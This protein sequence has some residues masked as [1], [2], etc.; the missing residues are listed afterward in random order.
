[1]RDATRIRRWLR[2]GLYCA[3]GMLVLF[4]AAAVTIQTPPGK[5]MLV[6][7]ITYFV[8][9]HTSFTI[10]IE[11]LSGWLPGQVR[12]ASLYLADT[13]GPFVDIE[14][15]DLRLVSA[16]LLRGRIRLTKLD[17]GHL[18]L[19]NRP[20][21]KQKWRIPRIPEIPVWPHIDA[22]NIKRM[23][24][25]EAVMGREAELAITGKVTPVEGASFPE[26]AL[27][28]TGPET[29]DTTRA[30][31][32]FHYVDGLPQ[33]WLEAY[34]ESL[35]PAFLDVPPPLVA[36]VD[37][38]GGRADWKGRVAVTAGDD[39]TLF[40][41]DARLMEGVSS[42]VE[43]D[44]MINVT[45][46]PFLSD[47]AEYLG[48]RLDAR[49]AAVLDGNGLLAV[50]SCDITSE[51]LKA[52]LGGEIQLEQK[53][54]GLS[55][56]VAHADIS[57][58]P[59]MDAD[60]GVL[61]AELDLE[62]KGPFSELA[63]A[64][65]ASVSTMVVLEADLRGG[66]AETASL[67]GVVTVYPG[68]LPLVKMPYT[69]GESLRLDFD[70]SFDE[71]AGVLQVK[72]AD[73][74]AAGAHLTFQGNYVP[75]QP[76]LNLK[77]HLDAPDLATTG[78][79]FGFALT[80]GMAGDVESS[81][82]E[83][84]LEF[85]LKLEGSGL[86]A[87]S[88]SGQQ[89]LV[90]VQGRCGEWHRMPPRA[91]SATVNAQ[92][93][94]LILADR[95]AGDWNL[96]INV[97]ADDWTKLKARDMLLTD[98]N[99]R[100]TGEGVFALSE[101]HLDLELQ[102]D[103]SSLA[104]LPVD[105]EGLPDGS[106]NARAN[107]GGTF[108]PLSLDLR[109][110]TDLGALGGLPA[111]VAALTG[112]E[113]HL[114]AEGVISTEAIRFPRFVVSGRAC[115]VEGNASYGMQS[116][117]VLA[118]VRVT[119]PDLKPVGAALTKKLSGGMS[120]EAELRG[121]VRDLSAHADI[122]G[123]DIVFEAN[124]SAQM[125]VAL[126]GSGLSGE[127]PEVSL[128]ARMEIGGEAMSATGLA[129]L[130][131]GRI[132]VAPMKLKS[133]AN[134][135]SGRIAYNLDSRKPEAE[136]T[137]ALNDLQSLGRMAGAACS[138]SADGKVT[139]DDGAITAD[140]KARS[141]TYGSMKAADIHL[142]TRMKHDGKGYSG[143]TG[144]D[145]SGIQ[146]GMAGL[147]SLKINVDGGLNEA[148]MTIAAE[149]ALTGGATESQPFT[150]RVKSRVFPGE[151]SVIVEE[152]KGVLGDFEY[153][154]EEP[155][156]VIVPASGITLNPTVLR[157]G[158]GRLHIQGRQEG[159]NLS[160]E[161]RVEALPLAAGA[162]FGIPLLTGTLDAD[163][164]LNGSLSDPLVKIAFSLNEVRLQNESAAGLAPLEAHGEFSLTSAGFETT[165][166][167]DMKDT[168][169]LECQ[170]A[171][172]ARVQLIPW[173][174]DASA[175]TGLS[176]KAMFEIQFEKLLAALGL[177]EH[178][179]EGTASGE[180]SLAGGLYRPD[181]RG[182]AALRQAVYEN[183]KTGTRLQNLNATLTAEDGI[184]RLT[185][186][187]ADM[188]GQK[189]MSASGEMR[190][191]YAEQ[192]P[193]KGTV[194]LSDARFAD[195]DY[196][197][198]RVNG[199]LNVEGSLKD[200]LLKGD[201]K[202]TPVE[203]SMPDEMP[204]KELPVLEVTEIRDGQAVKQEEEKGP[205]FADRVRLDIKCDI[206]G[207]VYARAP[208]LDSEWG[209]KLHVGGTLAEM[210]IDGRVAVLRG[211]LD[212]LNRR[213]Q[214]RDSALLFLDG[215][216][217]KPYL[218]MQAV[219]ETSSL[220]ARLTLKGE[221]DDVKIELSSDPV[222]PQD[223]ILAQILFG[224]NL[225]RLSPVQAIQL[226]RVA[227]MFNQGFAGV[228]FFSGNIKLPGIDRLDLRTGERAD[229]T[230]VGMGKYFTDSVYV[231]VE[232]GTTTDS[233]RV[234]VEVEVTPQISVKGDA[235]AKERSGVGLFWKKDY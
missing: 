186:C 21:P 27:E 127:H 80:G 150:L 144:M 158:T 125:N 46:T 39:D 193:F 160:A 213:F 78:A 2:R 157:F 204:V 147:S 215:S 108:Q 141:V 5:A 230:A 16:Q 66:L 128:D 111:P 211:H 98:G 93:Q 181:I 210:R 67:G 129:T 145:A 95:H 37:G 74:T 28:I 6:R 76:A 20:I 81:G 51:F 70:G 79:L 209:G 159:D 188:G 14:D 155:A 103:V 120:L 56:R 142:S 137:A 12:L 163:M 194:H 229:E 102:A 92:G 38:R 118:G 195:L 143:T 36:Q 41:G 183:T 132:V 53:Q 34:D 134:E 179:L 65:K 105:I 77:A 130:D 114:G 71:Q 172:A 196:M 101:K 167:A 214:L 109:L 123:T 223:E 166:K 201:I 174:L 84:G 217:E 208:I 90:T 191:L 44:L 207:K 198:G 7:G 227:A 232:Q 69:G 203:V 8:N 149:G 225:S 89:A 177:D 221:L 202:V 72:H 173:V 60:K 54:A 206:P 168:L 117:E 3:V 122:R 11:G 148:A 88:V 189:N 216:P 59:G 197:N 224:R 107:I 57:R 32:S 13:R 45:R 86:E 178:Y 222:L 9:Q 4:F 31:F 68:R 154:L 219:V 139:L 58:I 205:G 121:P 43:A 24:L 99:A 180:F 29:A 170:A 22:L 126:E 162:M 26:T 106:L 156:K 226:A 64:G 35:L 233:S 119:V 235:D 40:E 136:L 164:S 25:D 218:D 200:M 17:I 133:G 85:T 220:S 187:T 152:T 124:P 10:E 165:V 96:A 131:A 73:V 94:G 15:L 61:P 175:D 113:V 190:L 212:F 83:S 62:I 185:E 33:I 82:G 138:G 23:V 153:G 91:V 228:P 42:T 110:D 55:L 135:V 140:M 52:V 49:L 115:Q 30:S 161:T 192:F 182:E 171:L 234:S 146:A 169:R 151:R 100:L 47:Y 184:L 112:N 50:K 48:G 104:A 63:V 231:E 1:M 75:E 87:F 176:G 19:W 18:K 199:D 97:E 116:G